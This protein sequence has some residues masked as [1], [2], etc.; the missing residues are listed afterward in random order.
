MFNNKFYTTIQNKRQFKIL[1]NI[2]NITYDA[3]HNFN[4]IINNNY[5][6]AINV[7]QD[8]ILIN[9]R[10]LYGGYA[11]NSL[12]KTVNQ[13]I[14][15]DN[16]FP[17]FDFYSP[18]FIQDAYILCNQLYSVG[19][20]YVRMIP[21]LHPHTVRI[22][23]D[24]KI[25]IADI[26][27]LDPIEYNNIPTKEIEHMLYITPQYMKITLYKSL[28]L[29]I[30]AYRWNK[31]IYRLNLINQFFPEKIIN[32]SEYLS[33]LS[34]DNKYSYHKQLIIFLYNN[35]IRNQKFSNNNIEKEKKFNLSNNNFIINGYL[36]FIFYKSINKNINTTHDNIINYI[37]KYNIP[38]ELIIF[39]DNIH[40]IINQFMLLI[41]SYLISNNLKNLYYI[42]LDCYNG[43]IGNL[44]PQKFVLKIVPKKLGSFISTSDEHL[45]YQQ[46][47]ICVF[48]NYNNIPIEYKY[49]PT[50]NINLINYNGLIHMLYIYRYYTNN[51]KL[52][53]SEKK[54]KFKPFNNLFSPFYY[55]LLQIYNSHIF[56]DYL[57]QS[58]Q[59][60]KDKFLS[61]HNIKP[62]QQ[63]I[64]NSK[65][66]NIFQIISFTNDNILLY[67]NIKS[68][69]TKCITTLD[70][71][72]YGTYSPDITYYDNNDIA[73]FIE[74]INVKICLLS[75]NPS[76][77]YTND[78]KKQ[79]HTSLIT[80][81]GKI[82]DVSI[83]DITINDI[84]DDDIIDNNLEKR[85]NF[86]KLYMIHF[87]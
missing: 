48:Y 38:I 52:D 81:G 55:N 8:F 65:F 12:L 11:I 17:D 75:D 61:K 5:N 59:N 16:E 74:N 87:S 9:K 39:N 22:Q 70:I 15:D 10:I 37:N 54:T 85:F 83:D 31:D 72:N 30:N 57:I 7:V 46:F 62:F 42:I 53:F 66:P 34:N 80:K 35:I 77:N 44:L 19:F 67:N 76:S 36:A 6:K 40:F 69:N 71:L 25:Y 78:E 82:N 51:Y 20:K 28:S 13:P 47:P 50:L 86:K 4:T 63:F 58:L 23:I 24:F 64:N 43:Q 2:D 18:T 49:I 21:A 73:F 27:Y 3:N 45:L 1:K 26:S 84:I 68:I 14:Y 33:L 79:N 29:N 56:V 60:F 41:N 32:Q